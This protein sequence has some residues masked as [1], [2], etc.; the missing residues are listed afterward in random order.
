MGAWTITSP[1]SYAVSSGWLGMVF[2]AIATG[3]PILIIAFLGNAVQ[4]RWPRCS[5]LGDFAMLR[6]QTSPFQPALT[7]S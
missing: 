3:L 4:R 5:S 7:M 6:L 2:Y 1:P